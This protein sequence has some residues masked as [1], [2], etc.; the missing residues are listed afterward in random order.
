MDGSATV[1]RA[2]EAA[3]DG[4][5]VDVALDALHTLTQA[6]L[7]T[8]GYSDEDAATIAEVIACRRKNALSM[9]RGLG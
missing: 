9:F 5:T 2:P 1:S 7:A 6:A 8:I 3:E 4:K